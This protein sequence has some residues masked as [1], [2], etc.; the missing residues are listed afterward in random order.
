M[1]NIAH[2]KGGG[3]QALLKK[4]DLGHTGGPICKRINVHTI[5]K[6]ATRRMNALRDMKG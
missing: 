2:E 1:K 4:D 6:Q 5:K 3:K